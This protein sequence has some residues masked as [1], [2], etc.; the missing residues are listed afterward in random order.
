MEIEVFRAESPPQ[1][2]RY[3]ETL[4]AGIV[5]G[6][7]GSLVVLKLGPGLEL[8]E[9][10][11]EQEHV[12]AVLAGEFS[13]TAGDEATVLRTGD[14]YRVPPNVRHGVRCADHALVV[15]ARADFEIVRKT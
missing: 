8:A 7:M 6:N 13:F 3:G 2:Q 14:L 10:A 9:H 12:G 1:A 11:H 15:Q 5:R 4:E